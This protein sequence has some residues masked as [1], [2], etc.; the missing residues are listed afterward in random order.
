MV[1]ARGG[2]V[3]LKGNI[4]IAVSPWLQVCG[5][6]RRKSEQSE[7]GDNW[8]TCPT[9]D[10]VKIDLTGIRCGR[11][12]SSAAAFQR[13]R[14]PREPCLIPDHLLHRLDVTEV[15]HSPQILSFTHPPPMS[16]VRAPLRWVQKGRCARPSHTRAVYSP[17][18]WP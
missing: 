9:P 15:F 14:A 13:S 10:A 3:D 16:G 18:S 12:L 7:V 17:V 5:K 8:F 1:W 11:L 4:L 2:G 6:S